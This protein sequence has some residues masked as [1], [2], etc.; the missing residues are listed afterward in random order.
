MFFLSRASHRYVLVCIF[1]QRGSGDSSSVRIY[2]E[3]GETGLLG[4]RILVLCSDSHIFS[5]LRRVFLLNWEVFFSANFFR[6]FEPVFCFVVECQFCTTFPF[7]CSAP[8]RRWPESRTRRETP[9]GACPR[10]AACIGV[11]FPFLTALHPTSEPLQ[12]PLGVR[13]NISAVSPTI[14]SDGTQFG[15]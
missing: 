5:F 2:R 3:M 8:G 6:R 13:R 1:E 11:S 10:W 15:P 4:T 14:L 7:R 12:Q 9:G